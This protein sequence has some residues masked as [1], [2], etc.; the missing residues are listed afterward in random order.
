MYGFFGSVLF[1]HCKRWSINSRI[2][3]ALLWPSTVWI[4]ILNRS[5]CCI[6]LTFFFNLIVTKEYNKIMMK[7]ITQA[8]ELVQSRLCTPQNNI[9]SHLWMH[10]KPFCRGSSIYIQIHQIRT[11]PKKDP[12]KPYSKLQEINPLKALISFLGTHRLQNRYFVLGQNFTS[13]FGPRHCWSPKESIPVSCTREACAETCIF[14]PVSSKGPLQLR[15]HPPLLQHIYLHILL[16]IYVRRKNLVNFFG[17]NLR[18]SFRFHK[19]NKCKRERKRGLFT[20]HKKEDF[21][22]V[23]SFLGQNIEVLWTYQLLAQMKL[24]D[25]R[26]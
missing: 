10:G 14:S 18:T 3:S 20:C 5:P 4:I 8:R 17:D 6:L 22:M 25:S 23:F 1:I 24:R 16:S 15:V 12:V 7:L 2:Q 19:G 26:C 21:H 9:K 11:Y 13:V